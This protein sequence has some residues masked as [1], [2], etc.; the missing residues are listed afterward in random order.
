M[1][2]DQRTWYARW[3]QWNCRVLDRAWPNRWHDD[4]E[5]RYQ[6]GTNLCHFM[7]TIM[8]GSLAAVISVVAMLAPIA[9]LIVIPWLL[10]GLLPVASAWIGVITALAALVALTWLLA[11]AMPKAF[12]AAKA[13]AADAG[14]RA[15]SRIEAAPG[16]FG[17]IV[18]WLVAIK[19]RA[20]PTIR[21]KGDER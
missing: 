3:F 8:L 17:L 11:E 4:R 1:L 15:W 18:R 16:F 10:Y 14:D 12:A 2:I 9:A 5:S 21:F 7:R 13:R 19:Q 6:G 20:C